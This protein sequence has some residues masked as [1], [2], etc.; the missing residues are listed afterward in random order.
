VSD[1][2]KKVDS[3]KVYEGKIIS[4]YLDTIESP[5]GIKMKREIIKHVNAVGI[6]AI[7]EYDKMIFVRQYRHAVGKSLLEIPAGLLDS[8]DETPESCAIRELKE[9]TGYIAIAIDKICEFYT[10]AG[11]TDEKFILYYTD[12]IEPGQHDREADEE[13]MK[14]EEIDIEKAFEL[15]MNGEIEDSKT[16]TAIL[17]AAQRL[18]KTGKES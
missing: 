6:I 2:F 15:A 8:E 17:I 5:S 4:L 16:L 18:G 12:S 11:F 9:E 3:K 10:S 13:G 14:V 7:N 1:E